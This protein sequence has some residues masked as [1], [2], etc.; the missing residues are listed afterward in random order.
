MDMNQLKKKKMTTTKIIRYKDKR[1]G[2]KHSKT[3]SK[4]LE[5]YLGRERERERRK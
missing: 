4:Y 3:I 5:S 2:F 1:K